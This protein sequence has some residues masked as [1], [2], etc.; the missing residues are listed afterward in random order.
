[1]CSSG[2]GV[3]GRI[4]SVS[5]SDGQLLMLLS[6][7]LRCSYYTAQRFPVRVRL[8]LVRRLLAADE[9]ARGSEAMLS[10]GFDF[11]ICSLLCFAFGAKARYD[12]ILS[13]ISRYN[14][15][16]TRWKCFAIKFSISMN[17]Y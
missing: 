9:R 4:E 16:T 8:C 13:H 7:L 10:S 6:I 14:N 12:E 1:M 2:R 17:L 5:C 11:A 3:L 15:R